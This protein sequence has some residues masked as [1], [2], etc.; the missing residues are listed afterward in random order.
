MGGVYRKTYSAPIPVDGV[1]VTVT[2]KRRGKTSQVPGV[3]FKGG[4]GRAA[5]APLT[6]DGAR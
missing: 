2:V 3:R 6:G 5:T 1:L 4:D